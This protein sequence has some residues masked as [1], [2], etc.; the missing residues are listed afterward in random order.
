MFPQCR[1][2]TKIA[3][4]STRLRRRTGEFWRLIAWF[5]ELEDCEWR[6]AQTDNPPVFDTIQIIQFQKYVK[7]K[8]HYPLH[9][10]FCPLKNSLLPK[11]ST[12]FPLSAYFLPQSGVNTTLIPRAQTL[13]KD[14]WAAIWAK[15]RRPKERLNSQNPKPTVVRARGACAGRR[16]KCARRALP[17]F[18]CFCRRL[19]LCRCACSRECGAP[20]APLS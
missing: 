16:G 11:T 12:L 19:L 7:L 20:E 4:K 2:P 1:P 13:R 6:K 17:Y 15:K 8:Q 9:A 3:A 14:S 10:N 18:L 5:M